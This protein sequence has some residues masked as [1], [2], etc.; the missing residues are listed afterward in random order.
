MGLCRVR[1]LLF[2]FHKLRSIAILFRVTNK[3]VRFVNLQ[4][5]TSIRI[6]GQ[7]RL[8][9]SAKQKIVQPGI[10]GVIWMRMRTQFDPAD[11]PLAIA[12]SAIVAR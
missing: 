12:M 4:G 8:H 7:S 5:L 9:A 3:Y 11:V 10:V 1:H 2:V 6:G